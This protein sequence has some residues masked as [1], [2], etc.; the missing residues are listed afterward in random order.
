MLLAA[1]SDAH[2]TQASYTLRLHLRPGDVI[3]QSADIVDRND[4]VMP[5]AR[6]EA[7]RRSGLVI[8]EEVRHTVSAR[9]R[10]YSVA[11][12]VATLRGTAHIVE[13]DVPRNG[14]TSRYA[15]IDSSVT[16]LN[17]DAAGVEPLDISESAA[18]ALPATAVRVGETWTTSQRVRTTLGSGRVA[19]RHTLRSVRGSL[20]EIAVSGRGTI[21][22]D[23]YNL[24]RLLPG[25]IELTGTTWLDLRWGVATK[26]SY[27]IHNRLVKP[28]RDEAVG[29]DEHESVEISTHVLRDQGPG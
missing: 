6:L 27:R 1:G 28:V 24:P 29:F 10:V 16:E 22:G 7:F 26:E 4:W 21:T 12:G 20:L 11:H 9:A 15:P 23:E 5:K 2:A 13:R 17:N 14:R 18:A 3:A 25:S 8:N 19:F